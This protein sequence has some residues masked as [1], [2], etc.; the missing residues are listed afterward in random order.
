MQQLNL[1]DRI[2]PP[3]V[4]ER[5]FRTAVSGL[6]GGFILTI[7]SAFSTAAQSPLMAGVLF[8][9]GLLM[10]MA[11]DAPLITTS[12]GKER[13]DKRGFWKMA[14]IALSNIAGIVLASIL[15]LG[16]APVVLDTT[17]TAQ[18]FFNTIPSTKW[19]HDMVL[20]HEAR[21]QGFS[22][23]LTGPATLGLHGS[24]VWALFIRSILCGFMMCVA[25]NIR[26]NAS[27]DDMTT[28][29][30]ASLVPVMPSWSQA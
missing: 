24:G 8:S 5:R 6:L 30:V 26:K 3:S 12:V 17:A 25:V 29:V 27:A 20:A 1:F 18:T 9:V 7:A 14:N 2:F 23:L 10:C 21:L 11:L 22:T 28:I 19:L 15:L 13:W 16:M 4:R